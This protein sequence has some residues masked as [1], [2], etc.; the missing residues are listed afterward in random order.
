MDLHRFLFSASLLASAL[1][2][3]L[4]TA[5]EG[6]ALGFE[7]LRFD[8]DTDC[9]RTQEDL[10]GFDALKD[11]EIA[12]DVVLSIGGELRER[13]EYTR[14]PAF[15][16]D[17]QD[18]NGVWLQRFTLHGDLKVGEHIRL[19][20]QLF[21]AFEEGRAGGASPVDRNDLTVQNAFVDVRGPIAGG[22]ANLRFGRQE[23][24]FGSGR[25]IDVR[26]GPNVRRT[27]DAVRPSFQVDDWR[28]DGLWARPR[29]TEPGIFDD[30]QN[31]DQELWALYATKDNAFVADGTL[32]LY[33]LGF[34]NDGAS[35]AQGTA[36][37]ERHTLGI[38]HAGTSGPWDWNWEAAYQF[39]S[40]GDGDI[41]AWTLATDTGYTFEQAA[42]RPRLGLGANI[43]SGD[44]DSGDNDLGTFNPIFPRGNYFSEAA[45]LGPRNFYNLHA[46]LTV[47]PTD[48]LTLQTDYNMFWRLEEEDGVYSPAG[49]LIVPSG[50]EDRFVASAL[51]FTAEY[52]LTER[53]ALAGIYT[54]VFAGDVIDATAN[55]EDI[56]F[57]E[58]TFS[59]R[60]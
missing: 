48:R 32:D 25:F 26:E 51:S 58:L 27:F 11:I 50:G 5:Q 2:P 60:F 43:A 9:F 47:T 29:I 39:G 3:S 21:S 1:A 59:F 35:F 10:T 24:Q 18:E 45:V 54:R 17:P 41:N 12:P 42:W 52:A 46:F 16:A 6:C 22:H 14:N 40:F 4:A 44:S 30:R 38:R 23:L 33:Y 28:I 15:S 49:N 36:D 20:G 8:D 7:K 55:S 56:D 31:D 57:V 34:R 19:F 37:E 53:V 13:Y